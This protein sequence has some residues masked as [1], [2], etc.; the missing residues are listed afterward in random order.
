[1]KS[2]FYYCQILLELEYSTQIFEKPLNT[3]LHENPSGGSPADKGWTDRHDEANI[4][5]S[6]YS[7]RA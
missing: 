2:N 5:F 3:K 6:Q 1:M 4:R 7:E